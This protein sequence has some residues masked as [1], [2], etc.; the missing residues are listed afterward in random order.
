VS[1]HKQR[2]EILGGP[3]RKI[4][5]PRMATWRI[6]PGISEGSSSW[7]DPMARNRTCLYVRDEL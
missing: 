5:P 3:Q 7:S 4:Y 6:Y 1:G 2:S